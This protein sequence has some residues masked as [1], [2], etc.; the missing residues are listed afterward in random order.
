MT[1]PTSKVEYK[2]FKHV[3]HI[4]DPYERPNEISKQEKQIWKSK[5]IHDA[6]FKSMS[7][8]GTNFTKD[9]VQY[10]IDDKAKL[11]MSQKKYHV[12]GNSKRVTH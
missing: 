1:N 4:P 2:L 10:G 6:M 9:K 8:G 12:Y 7:H 5:I 3:A 11:T